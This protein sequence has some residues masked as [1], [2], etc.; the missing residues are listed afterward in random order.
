MIG[1]GIVALAGIV[2]NNNIVLIDTYNRLLSDGRTPE[3]A[4][5]ATAA[6]RIR[7]IL[8]TTGTT[9]CGL[10]P[11]IIQMN[12]N[13]FEGSINFGGASSEW[14]VQLATAVVFGLGFSTIMILLVTP[15]WLLAPHRIRRWA[16]R[17]KDRVRGEQAAAHSI[18]EQ[19][20]ANENEPSDR[21]LPAAE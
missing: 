7:P 10:L 21:S 8:L 16:G 11:M 14:W 12:V 20:T 15:V 1:T 17:L 13:F 4:A 5:V 3:E 9:I 2:V 18:S 19:T 6:Q